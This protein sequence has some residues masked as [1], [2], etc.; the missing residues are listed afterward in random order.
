MSEMEQL[1]EENAQLREENRLLKLQIE[2]L[3]QKFF[4]KN[5]PKPEDDETPHLPKKRGAPEGHPGKT[6]PVPD[7]FDEHMDVKLSQCPQCGGHNLSTCSRHEDHYQEDIVLP[8]VK[9]TRFRH[10]FYW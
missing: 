10:H 7:H 8:Q 4:K 6:R 3:R 9:V 1:K 2:E 5:T